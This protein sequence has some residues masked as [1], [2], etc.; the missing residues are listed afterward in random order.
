MSRGRGAFFDVDG[1]LVASDVVRYGV[2]VHTDDRPPLMRAAWIARFVP[3]IPWFL[4]LDLVDRAAFQ[5][6]FYRIYRGLTPESLAERAERL[7]DDHV[8]PRIVPRAVDRLEDHRGRGHRIVLVTG[9]IRPIV[10]PLAR[11]LGVDDLLAPELEVAGGR[12]TGEL[13][14]PP[15]AGTRKAAALV[16][17]AEAEELDRST[18]WAYADSRDDV[19]MLAAVGRPAVVNPGRKLERIARDRGWGVYRWDDRTGPGSG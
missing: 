10:A 3:R 7:F 16:G 19:P 14:S 15:L 17:F 18:S 6:S 5:R 9:S 11:H 4:A 1:T 8:R 12:Y 13:E 2:H